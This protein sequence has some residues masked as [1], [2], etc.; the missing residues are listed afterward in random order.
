[1]A[2]QI[3]ANITWSNVDL[4]SNPFYG[5]H[6]R[7][8]SQKVIRSLIRNIFGYN[9]SDMPSTK[10]DHPF[11]AAKFMGPTWGPSGADRTQAPWTWLSGLLYNGWVQ[12]TLCVLRA[13]NKGPWLFGKGLFVNTNLPYTNGNCQHKY[14]QWTSITPHMLLRSIVNHGPQFKANI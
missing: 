4:L 2:T 7:A 13:L 12:E 1:M 5:I 9:I 10:T 6:L 8:I 3:W 14:W 11:Q